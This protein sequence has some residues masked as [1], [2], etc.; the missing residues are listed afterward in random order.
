MHRLTLVQ[1]N[2]LIDAA[3]ADAQQR[4]LRPVS[5]VVLDPGGNLIALQR[6]D[7]APQLGPKLATGKAAGALALG[8]TSRRL[9]EMA[10]ERPHFI[11]AIGGMGEGGMVPAAGGIIVCDAKG[12]AIGA[13]GISGDTSDNDEACALAAIAATGFTAKA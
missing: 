12:T 10:V 8:V 4:G 9:G 2:A 7:G 13:L 11:A 3:Q 5:V 6:Q 1:A